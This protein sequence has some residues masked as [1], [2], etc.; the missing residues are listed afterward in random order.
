MSQKPN[1]IIEEKHQVNVLEESSKFIVNIS[2]IGF[3]GAAFIIAKGHYNFWS[4]IIPTTTFT[5]GMLCRSIY[6]F[7]NKPDSD[8]NK[9][10]FD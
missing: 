6:V 4:I 8:K 1:V 7:K 3:M 9:S 5:I 10:D 2:L